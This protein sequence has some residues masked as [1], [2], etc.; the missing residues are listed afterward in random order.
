MESSK[1]KRQLRFRKI[2]KVKKE[3]NKINNKINSV[4][5][6]QSAPMGCGISSNNSPV[7]TKRLAGRARVEDCSPLENQRANSSTSLNSINRTLNSPTNIY[8]SSNFI[9]NSNLTNKKTSS[10]PTSLDQLNALDQSTTFNPLL[11]KNQ[12][13]IT[14][15]LSK[16][17]SNNKSSIDQLEGESD[18]QTGKESIETNNSRNDSNYGSSYS[19]EM[20]KTPVSFIF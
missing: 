13:G 10:S 7:V 9:P 4:L 1:T 19:A 14:A 5:S 8:S 2:I 17:L 15:V 6:K 20:N 11:A 18:R 16:T 12:R 3:A